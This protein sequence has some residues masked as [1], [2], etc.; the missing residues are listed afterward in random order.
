LN[1]ARFLAIEDVED[2]PILDAS[3]LV[4]RN[5]RVPARLEAVSAGRSKLPT[6]SARR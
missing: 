1:P 6:W 3:Q 4:M 2:V 5:I